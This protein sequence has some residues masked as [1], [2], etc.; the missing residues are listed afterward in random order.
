[1]P[2][3]TLLRNSQKEWRTGWRILAML[4]LLAAVVFGLLHS[5]NPGA[6]WQGLLYTVIG[7]LLMS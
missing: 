4:A 5:G 6:N 1:M 2:L 7:G 3:E